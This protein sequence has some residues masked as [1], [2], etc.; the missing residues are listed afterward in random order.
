MSSLLFPLSAKEAKKKQKATGIKTSATDNKNA[1]FPTRLRELRAEKKT[2]EG[3]GTSQQLLA[4]EIGV[5]KSTISLY[6]MG[7]NVPD[8]KT[9][10]K[11][12]EFYNVSTDYLLGLINIKSSNIDFQGIHRK[13]GLSEKAIETLTKQKYIK[14][15]TDPKETVYQEISFII[16]HKDF[17][18]LIKEIHFINN[19][20]ENLCNKSGKKIEEIMVETSG[21]LRMPY[22][23]AVKYFKQNIIDN[24]RKILDDITLPINILTDDNGKDEI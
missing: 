12:A 23:H 15:Y 18:E 11:L 22:N 19:I 3:K 2:N 9:I 16:E 5:T 4:D 10:V 24:F 8:A 17:P 6:E 14:G 1:L 20:G 13:T 7:D 21:G